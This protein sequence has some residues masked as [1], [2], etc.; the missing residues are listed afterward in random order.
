M[1][2][3]TPPETG[4]SSSL[5]P[6]GFGGG[7]TPILLLGG[8]KLD[9]VPR[10][11][12]G[13]YT[14]ERYRVGIPALKPL[15][16]L[17]TEAYSFHAAYTEIRRL[18]EP[19]RGILGGWNIQV[20]G[21]IPC[22]SYRHKPGETPADGDLTVLIIAPWRDDEDAQRWYNA[23]ADIRDLLGSNSITRDM[24]IKVELV[25]W[26]VVTPKLTDS[27]EEDHPIEKAWDD[28]I[29]SGV[30]AILKESPKVDQAWCTLGVKRTG[31]RFEG[32]CSMPVTVSIMVDF[33]LERPD[34]LLAEQQIRA[35]L[36]ENGLHEVE[37]EFCHGEIWAGC[38]WGD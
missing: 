25:A 11:L 17:E 31:Y 1:A 12:A 7:D 20:P 8:P 33:E 28:K 37:I 3:S 14:A 19:V 9:I 35:L 16:L 4:S 18:R 5:I 26:N 6:D 13:S 24:D 29:H 21:M 36:D 27:V 2:S 15:P 30:L 10:P 34:W 38:Y 32:Y 23:A 22:L